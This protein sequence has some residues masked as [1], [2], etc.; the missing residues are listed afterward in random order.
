MVQ[1]GFRQLFAATA[2]AA[3]AGVSGAAAGERSDPEFPTE[4][5]A[6]IRATTALFDQVEA[7]HAP[8]QRVP[9]IGI[10]LTPTKIRADA[11]D[12]ASAL[13]RNGP[14]DH[15]TGYRITWYPMERLLGSVDFMGTWG[16]NRNLVCGYLT[17]DLTDP[18]T[19][20][21]EQIQA[22][23]VDLA[24]IGGSSDQD[25]HRHLLNANCAF[26][27]IEANFHVFDVQ[28]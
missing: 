5:A 23:F 2:F 12:H 19:P 17:W 24:E 6:L 11:D 4:S 26:G 8:R 1:N 7:R 28:G 27:A 14:V 9:V 15:L 20:R 21:L 10:P 3:L 25:I 18:D 13:T 22:S 16:G